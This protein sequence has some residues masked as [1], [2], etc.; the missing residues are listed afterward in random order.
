MR[1]FISCPNYDRCHHNIT[2]KEENRFRDSYSNFDEAYYALR[3]HLTSDPTN[4]PILQNTEALLKLRSYV[5]S[6]DGAPA[7][8]QK[9]IGIEKRCIQQHQLGHYIPGVG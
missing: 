5:R 4:H 9:E 6:G 2:K 1:W 3:I 8:K 7:R